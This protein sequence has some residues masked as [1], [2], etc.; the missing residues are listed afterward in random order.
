MPTSAAPEFIPAGVRACHRCSS[1]IGTKLQCVVATQREDDEKSWRSRTRPRP[2]DQP[3]LRRYHFP[4]CSS[5]GDPA[6]CLRFSGQRMVY[7]FACVQDLWASVGM[8]AGV[9]GWHAMGATQH[10]AAVCEHAKWTQ[11]QTKRVAD[12]DEKEEADE[13]TAPK[14]TETQSAKSE[15]DAGDEQCEALSLLASPTASMATLKARAKAAD[16]IAAAAIHSAEVAEMAADEAERA[17]ALEVAAAVA[18]KGQDAS[19]YAPAASI[20]HLSAGSFAGDSSVRSIAGSD[21][22]TDEEVTEDEKAESE[23]EAEA[24]AETVVAVQM[25]PTTT[26][27]DVMPTKAKVSKS[28]RGRE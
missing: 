17:L 23:A 20:N 2:L 25:M 18:A 3:A 13:A 7:C 11:A 27:E 6:F 14:A 5:K 8:P 16:R 28:R 10:E 22:A 26:A 4:V 21:D 12:E 9:V 1:A 24:A 15:A 19:A